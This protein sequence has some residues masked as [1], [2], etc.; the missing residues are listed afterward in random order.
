MMQYGSYSLPNEAGLQAGWPQLC[1]CG[2]AMRL[3]PNALAQSWKSS[4]S[5]SSRKEKVG[6]KD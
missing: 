4:S 2:Y 6:D 1:S 3:G 5:T